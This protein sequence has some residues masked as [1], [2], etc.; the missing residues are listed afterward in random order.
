MLIIFPYTSCDDKLLDYVLDELKK[1]KIKHTK[2]LQCEKKLI[3][4]PLK[5]TIEIKNDNNDENDGYDYK[6]DNE[7]NEPNDDLKNKKIDNNDGL[8]NKKIDNND[9]LDKS[10]RISKTMIELYNSE[11]GKQLK[12]ISHEKR[13]ETMSKEKEAL[14]K[15]LTEKI[16]K[17][18]E[19]LKT[20]DNFNKKSDT[21]DGFQ[22]YCRAC[23]NAIKIAKR[24]AVK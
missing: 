19:M 16:C 5:K 11:K 4:D 24:N 9:G 2:L 12:K 18:C 17:H 22:P 21:K 14:R 3:D 20:I 1:N 8:K 7:K 6:S 10:E 15:N 13:S 23:I